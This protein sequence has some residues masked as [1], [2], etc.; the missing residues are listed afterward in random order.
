M[1]R[2]K[3]DIKELP[4]R[5]IVIV[6]FILL[7]LTTIS[8]IGYI[9]F[10]NWI[11]SADD[12]ITKLAQD[13]N[14]EIY[15]EIDMF[16]NV[17]EQINEMNQKLLENNIVDLNNEIEREKYFVGVLKTQGYDVY[18]FSYGTVNGEYYGARRNKNND[19]EIMK[20]N[21]D[22]K[23]H[24]FYYSITNE[25]TSSELVV[26]AGEFDPRTRNWYK[27]AK[28]NQKPMFS[29]IY[30]HFIMDDLTISAAVPIYKGGELQGVLGSHITLSRIDNY[31]REIV[32]D[33]N[34][35]AIIIE[36][37]T[38]KLIANSLNM[39]NFI[40]LDDGTIKRLTINE[41]NNEEVLKSY[42]KYKSIQ[43]SNFKIKNNEDNL[44][45]NLIEYQKNGIDWIV[46]LAVPFSLF[47]AGIFD[48]MKLASLLI[49]IA[50]IISIFFYYKLT[51]KLLK[52]IDNLIDT[53]EK[54]TQ[55]DLR[56]RAVTKRN[57]EIGKLTKSFNK[58]A[59][60]ISSL[61]F[62]LE[63]KVKERTLELK[64]NKDY[65]Q[66]ILNST[67]QA[68]YGMDINGKCTF[69]N[70]SGLK[71]LGYSHQDELLGKDIHKLIHHTYKDG[72]TMPISECK[73]YKA[74][75]EGKG[76]NA[77]DE[78]FWRAD[79]TSFDVEYNS[80][81]QYKEGK[82]I[83]A[84]VTFID[85]TERKKNEEHIKYISY[86]D[87]LTDL[88]NRTFFESELK[89]LDTNE[90]LPISII[91]GDV[92]GLKLTNDIFGH[93]AGDELLKRTADILKNVCREKDIV[94]RVGGDEFAIVLPNTS[95]NDAE[96]IIGRLKIEISKIKIIAIKA[97]M[98]MGYDTKIKL[99]QDLER[100]MENAE[101]KMYQDKTLNRSKINSNLLNTIM[102]TL[103]DLSCREKTHSINV[104]ELCEDIG[105]AM[106]LTETNIRKLKQAGFFHDIGKI[107]LNE[108]ILINDDVQ[109]EEENKEM[110]KHAVIGYRILNLFDNTV[111]LA[112]GILYHH[113]NWNGTGYPKGIK[114]EEIPRLARIIRVAESYDSMTNDFTNDA[115]TKEEALKEI[116]KQSGIIYDPDIVGIFIKMMSD[117]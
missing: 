5:V 64:E 101:E 116:K 25:M 104:S 56:I 20:N 94:A 88:Y 46:I 117:K 96:K 97:S 65:L 27:V 89:R 61:V 48:N 60:T 3:N 39:D 80:Y 83:G 53:T 93:V 19:I 78:V 62:N 22:T 7:M 42:E 113:E 51:N 26:D 21:A 106:N 72:K 87:S 74:L 112:E 4:I 95:G 41:V 59:D 58:M 10:F 69:C 110:E 92:N 115:M 40:T 84:V 111:D 33:K 29:A 54:L 15:H 76:T 81:P 75:L 30:K 9:V 35:Y 49:V 47:T 14:E 34:A 38:G 79:G 91:F 23:G 1:R 8:L 99:E 31:L 114:G 90:N 63:S 16:M 98:S 43:S 67:V 12:T 103:H 2:I 6:S 66:L 28:D 82:V 55:G 52:P 105:Y 17:P 50:L 45:I 11:S 100:T 37:N 107:I 73:I 24:S 70:T 102:E 85:I 32:K 86:H 77:N 13:M 36:K 44:H 108:D 109:T 18:S 71:I 68:I 57:D